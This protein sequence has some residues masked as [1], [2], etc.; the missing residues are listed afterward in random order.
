MTRLSPTTPCGIWFGPASVPPRIGGCSSA[1]VAPPPPARAVARK[2]VM[3][4]DNWDHDSLGYQQTVFGRVKDTG[5]PIGEASEFAARDLKAKG[6]DGALLIAEDAHIRLAHPD[7]NGGVEL[8][9]RGYNYT[10]GVDSSTGDLQAGLFFIAFVN[11][12]DHFVT[13]QRSL[14]TDLLN[15]YRIGF[16]LCSRVRHALIPSRLHE[17]T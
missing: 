2:V 1:S 3:F 12:P 14:G 6:D 5:A 4:I 15:E 9:R 13:V 11:D 17:N 16:P 10:G 7:A 8:L